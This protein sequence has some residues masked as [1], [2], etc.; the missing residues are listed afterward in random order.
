M[1]HTILTQISEFS[2]DMQRKKKACSAALI[3]SLKAVIS[4]SHFKE[5]TEILDE[6]KSVLKEYQ[7]STNTQ[8]RLRDKL[9][10]EGLSVTNTNCVVEGNLE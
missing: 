4:E 2:D 8:A 5:A 10:L 3:V 6:A 9:G 1:L 7:Q